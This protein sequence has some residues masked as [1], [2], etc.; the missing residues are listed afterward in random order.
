MWGL[1]MWD[2]DRRGFV[3]YRSNGKPD[4]L[5][6][7]YVKSIAEDKRGYLWLGTNGGGLSRFNP[8]DK[9]FRNF[10]TKDN[11]G[12]VNDYI[13]VIFMDSRNRLWIGTYFGLSCMDTETETLTSFKMDSG[14]SSMAV[15]AIA[16][17]EQGVIWIGTQNGLNR[18]N[19]DKNNFT[20]IRPSGQQ[21]SQVIN[22]IVPHKENLWLS[23]N[24]GIVRF[25]PSSLLQDLYA[26]RRLAERRVYPGIL[27]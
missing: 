13:S 7:D 11:K 24:K 8:A 18:Y 4:G 23:T 6:S 1:C 2:P 5:S 16:E 25:N 3:T 17:D 19:P 10:Q 14:L 15:Y 12:L 20:S 26:L 9:T 22:G 27:L 21:I